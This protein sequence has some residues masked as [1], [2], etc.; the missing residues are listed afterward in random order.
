MT[1]PAI[2]AAP[3]R[4]VPPRIRPVPALE[5]PSGPRPPCR[6][7]RRG[8]RQLVLEEQ[9]LIG[10]P[11][12]RVPPYPVDFFDPQP[13]PRQQLPPPRPWLLMLLRAALECVHGWRPAGQLSGLASDAV[14]ASLR[15]QQREAA[16]TAIPRV[17]S[18]HLTEPADGVVEACAVIGR[19]DRVHSLAIRLEGLDGRWRCVALETPR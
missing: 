14:L 7:I 12:P 16:G 10:D 8:G 3:R 9:A 2:A 6:P 18:L 4:C 1:I 11:G 17:H 15:H 5:P 19:G 13:T